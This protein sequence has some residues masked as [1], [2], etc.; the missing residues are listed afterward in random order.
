LKKIFFVFLSISL[1]LSVSLS[2]QKK[3]GVSV[4]FSKQEGLIRIVFEAEESFINKTKVITLASQIKIQFPEGFS[5]TAQKDAPFEILQTDKTVMINSKELGE[6][7]F[8]RLSS[9]ARLVFD[10]RKKEIQKEKQTEKKLEKQTEKTAEKQPEKQPVTI[11]SKVFVIDAG[12]G[13][14]D[15]GITSG[16]VNEKDISLSLAKDL[17]TVLSKK[18]K[19]VFLTRKVD[20]YISL[21][22]RINLVNQKSPDVFIS[23]HSSMSEKFI[24]YSPK[25]DEQGSNEIVDFYSISS[26]Q[27]KYI[28]K[29]KALS[30]SIG[31]AIEDEFKTDIIRREM[32][33]PL[34]NSAGAPSVLI[35]LPSPKFMVYDQQ[36][37]ARLENSIINGVAA[38]GQ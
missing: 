26:R 30:V 2:A 4:K 10:I 31:K 25:F 37:K 14:Y 38:Y 7:K 33:L 22:D 36:M 20:Q 35:E 19:K 29:S 11:L 12:H 16:D 32:P 24:L 9:P 23:L 3:T 15:F 28:E 27:R 17:N 8:F 5:L 34:L 18:G 6:I 13:G 21:A 1:L